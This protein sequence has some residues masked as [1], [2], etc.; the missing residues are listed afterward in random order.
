MLKQ[1]FLFL[2]LAAC[3]NV[4][5]QE[6]GII[7]TDQLLQWKENSSDTVYVLNFWATWCGPCVQELPDFEKLNS[8]F[9]NQKVQ[10]ILVSNDF[11]KTL[12]TKVKPFVLEHQLKSKVVLMGETD[13]NTWINL[14]SPDWSGALPATLIISKQKNKTL[15]FEKQMTYAALEAAVRS[16]L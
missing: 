3:F 6:I 8:N 16:L 1:I 14:V 13:P 11:S 12:E 4:R 2:L 7:K 5:A 15:F 10:V 9:A